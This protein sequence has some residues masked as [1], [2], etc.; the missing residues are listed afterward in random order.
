MKQTTA[1]RVGANVRAEMTR[2]GVSQ[3]T[4]AEQLGMSQPALSKRLLGKQVFDVDELARVAA[5]LELDMS[6]LIAG[7]DQRQIAAP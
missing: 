2:A 1:E 6:V 3:T 7:A 4:L 5:A